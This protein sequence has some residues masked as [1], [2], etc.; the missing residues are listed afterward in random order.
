ARVHVRL[1]AAWPV[2][3]GD[4]GAHHPGPLRHVD[5]GDP[6]PDPLMLLLV[7]LPRLLHG[8]HLPY[9]RA[10]EQGRAARGSRSGKGNLTGVLVATMRDL[11]RS[12]PQRLA[13]VRTGTPRWSRLYDGQSAPVSPP[14]P[15][16][17]TTTRNRPHP[18]R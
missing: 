10:A 1:A 16:A 3:L 18:L 12:G 7:N 15:P 13:I 11:S 8:G 17:G 5:R 4:P 6:L 9:A 2:L 14:P